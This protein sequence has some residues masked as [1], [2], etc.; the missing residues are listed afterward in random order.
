MW[1][2][3]YD[4]SSDAAGNRVV[5]TDLSMISDHCAAAVAATVGAVAPY[6]QTVIQPQN[7]DSIVYLRQ[8]AST[9]GNP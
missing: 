8:K 9:D 1:A 6:S 4:A 7:P 5:V 2:K 3:T